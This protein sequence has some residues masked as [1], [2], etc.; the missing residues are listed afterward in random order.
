MWDA[1]IKGGGFDE[2]CTDEGT[3]PM[4]CT[5]EWPAGE[6]TKDFLDR[7]GSA[8]KGQGA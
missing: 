8:Y 3:G 1:K 7:D 6:R 4:F 2:E 5:I